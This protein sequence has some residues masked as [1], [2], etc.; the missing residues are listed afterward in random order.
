LNKDQQ[1]ARQE[2]V[3]RI[4]LALANN[5][6]SKTKLVERRVQRNGDIEE[7]EGYTAN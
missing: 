1:Q 3:Q 7:R 2:K 5:Q 6:L 4:K